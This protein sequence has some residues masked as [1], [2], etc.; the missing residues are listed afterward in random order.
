MHPGDNEEVIKMKKEE[1]IKRY[2]E[3]KYEKYL[4]Q[5][6][7]WAEANPDRVKERGHNRSRKGG[8]NYEKMRRYMNTGIQEGKNKIRVN[9]RKKWSEYKRI[10]APGSQIHHQWIPKTANYKGVAL[11]EADQHRYGNIDVIQILDGVITV[12]TE[13][14]IHKREHHDN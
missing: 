5:T 3:A 8:K 13:K 12:F 9:H 4:E 1:F 11:V 7:Q 14:E 6:R 10:I 2:G